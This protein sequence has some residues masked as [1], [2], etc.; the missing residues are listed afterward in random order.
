MLTSLRVRV[1]V[2][3]KQKVLIWAPSTVFWGSVPIIPRYANL[4]KENE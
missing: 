2:L 1:P 4:N 3:S